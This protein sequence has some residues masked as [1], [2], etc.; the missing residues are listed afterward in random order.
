MDR[1]RHRPDYFMYRGNRFYFHRL[2]DGPTLA[3]LDPYSDGEQMWPMNSGRTIYVTAA[4]IRDITFQ[5]HGI[6]LPAVNPDLKTITDPTFG[7]RIAELERLVAELAKR[8]EEQQLSYNS[9]KMDAAAPVVPVVPAEPEPA[10]AETA[11]EPATIA[12]AP[13]PEPE[14]AAIEEAPA[15]P[16]PE[17]ELTFPAPDERLSD[18]GETQDDDKLTTDDLTS[19]VIQKLTPAKRKR[20]TELLNIE[21]SELQ[22]ERG[23]PREALKREA[24]IEATLGLFSRVGEL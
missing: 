10:H 18:Y 15:D 9:G 19:E 17:L 4:E 11:P 21:L 7:P 8:I 5:V 14:P 22:Q 2:A 23:G 24:A 3:R 12:V 16:E 6:E 1:L 13:D 20:F